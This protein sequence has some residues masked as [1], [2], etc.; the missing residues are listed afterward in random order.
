M[1]EP[2]CAPASETT[3]EFR[4]RV[5]DS[6]LETIGATPLVRLSKLTKAHA[7]D[8]EI[9]GK[10]E[11]FNPLS[12]VK[13]RIGYAMIAALEAAGKIGPDTVIVEPTSGNTGIALAFVCAAKGYRLMLTMPETMSVERRKMLRLLG[14][15]LVL[16][17]GAEGMR[18]AIAMAEKLIEELP[19][20]V[21]PQQFNNPANPEIHR[22][23]T[24][25]EIWK[26]SRGAV[27]A[28]VSG[29]G[30]G[31]TLT[32]IACAL[33]ERKPGVR[34]IA[35]EPEDSPVLSGGPPGP[36]R[37]QGIG[38]GFIQAILDTKCI[39]EVLC[40]GNDTAFATAREAAALEGLPVGI[41]SGAALAAAL[42]VGARPEMKGKTIVA[43][44]PSH[45]ERYLTT[46]LFEGL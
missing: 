16:T 22:L 12:S 6:I 10:C 8:A 36:H 3:G 38:A 21:M 26:D 27:D 33:K 45:S 43:I 1:A 4:G 37:I 35:V 25:E 2:L 28:V 40:I 44:L 17:D 18:G 30:T 31:G 39:D 5:Y 13:D 46:D 23:T 34:M 32:G 9:L 24:A 29:V 42:E 41:S 11:F 15:E 14:A 7:V 19:D 20:A